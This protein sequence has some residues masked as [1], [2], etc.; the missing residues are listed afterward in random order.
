MWRIVGKDKKTGKV[1]EITV[2]DNE[3][4]RKIILREE[5]HNYHDVRAVGMNVPAGEGQRTKAR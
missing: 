5:I 4:E 3:A 1:V 2:A